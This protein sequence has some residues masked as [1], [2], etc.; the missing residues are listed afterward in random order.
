MNTLLQDNNNA[1]VLWTSTVHSVLTVPNLLDASH[2]YV[3]ASLSSVSLKV[4]VTTSLST[5]MTHFALALTSLPS[6]NLYINNHILFHVRN[7]C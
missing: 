3:P 6:L 2:L 1:S 4:K 7:M 5:D